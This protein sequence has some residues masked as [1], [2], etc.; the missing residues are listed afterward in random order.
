MSDKVIT[1]APS[2]EDW[3]RYTDSLGRC[4]SRGGFLDRFYELFLSASDEIRK[5]FDGTDFRK[6][7]QMLGASFL[8]MMS[9]INGD[10]VAM[11]DLQERAARHSKA[12]LDIKPEWYEVWLNCLIQAVAETD[13]GY[14]DAVGVSW[15]NVMGP[16]IDFMVSQYES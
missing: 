6:Q 14:T 4:M 7:K 3:E 11:A 12:D 2:Y 1:K 9:A 8:T 5:K 16:G 15:R 13:S 10:K